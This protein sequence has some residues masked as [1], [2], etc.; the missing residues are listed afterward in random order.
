[1]S[2]QPSSQSAAPSTSS[3]P[4]TSSI[5]SSLSTTDV[6]D[7]NNLRI[8][9]A[10]AHERKCND[11][12][13]RS[14]HQHVRREEFELSFEYGIESTSDV[15]SFFGELETLLLDLVATSA[16]KCLQRRD[17]ESQEFVKVRDNLGVSEASKVAGVVR[18]R[19]PDVGNATSITQCEPTSSQAGYC[20]ILTTKM[21]VTSANLP[22]VVAHHDVLA[23]IAIALD[24]NSFSEFLPEQTTTAYLG[25][26]L[27]S[28]T[29]SM[30][31]A[32]EAT[33][34]A[35]RTSPIA[36][37]TAVLSIG[38]ILS[39]IAIVKLPAL[40]TTHNAFFERVIGRLRPKT[41]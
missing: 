6:P 25:P 30:P 2:S 4:S 21:L 26:N 39:A 13:L 5:P 17:G 40:S 10:A 33:N 20:S 11:E 23:V 9:N 14:M 34:D 1:M 31:L 24:Q 7:P 37:V 38:V 32:E 35:R 8:S 41:S 36:T 29:L 18:I 16:L 22:M 19:F 12:M 3:K 27:D 15:L 28:P